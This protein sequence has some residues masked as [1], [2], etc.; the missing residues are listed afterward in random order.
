MRS[1][2]LKFLMLRRRGELNIFGVQGYSKLMHVGMLAFQSGDRTAVNEMFD[3]L[4]GFLCI[5]G[6]SVSD[7]VSQLS[8]EYGVS[9]TI[10][11]RQRT[12]RAPD[13]VAEELKWAHNYLDA[14]QS[15]GVPI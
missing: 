11:P 6:L 13:F 14:L 1:L 12:E 7:A 9:V 15:Q 3:V 5:G 4:R 2:R 10:H 8:K